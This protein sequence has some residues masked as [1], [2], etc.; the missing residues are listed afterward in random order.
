MKRFMKKYS[1]EK[2]RVVK[3]YQIA[4]IK[5]QNCGVPMNRD[6]IFIIANLWAGL[7]IFSPAFLLRGFGW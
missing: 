2:V 6:E 3:K 5:I 7:G 4:K 1:E